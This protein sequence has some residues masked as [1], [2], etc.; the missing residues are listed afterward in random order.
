MSDKEEKLNNINK[1]IIKFHLTSQ[2]NNKIVSMLNKI[3]QIINE[4]IKEDDNPFNLSPIFK[5]ELSSILNKNKTKDVNNNNNNNKM[6][7][8]N[9]NNKYN[10]KKSIN[11]EN[12]NH[13]NKN[14]EL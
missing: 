7:K 6:V 10:I 11:E 9:E 14:E 13:N 4:T 3:E 5:S 1:N 8:E 12:I 2:I